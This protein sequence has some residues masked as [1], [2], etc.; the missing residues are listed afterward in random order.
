ME[1][2]LIMENTQIIIWKRVCSY[3]YF[4]LRVGALSSLASAEEVQSAGAVRESSPGRG[5]EAERGAETILEL[6]WV[7]GYTVNLSRLP[8]GNVLDSQHSRDMG[9]NCVQEK[10]LEWFPYEF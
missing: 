2:D 7:S 10:Q 8:Q 3:T 4:P 1:D 9:Q 6:T 5:G